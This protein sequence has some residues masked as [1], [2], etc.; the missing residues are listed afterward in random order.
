MT[1]MGWIRS[2]LGV[3]IPGTLAAGR[4][5][6]GASRGWGAGFAGVGVCLAPYTSQAVQLQDQGLQELGG[7]GDCKAL[8]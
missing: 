4:G 3:D 1:A 2:L 8:P 5:R 6:G 7:L